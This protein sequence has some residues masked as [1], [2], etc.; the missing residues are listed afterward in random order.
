MSEFIYLYRG[1]N[2][3]TLSPE[4]MQKNMEK[5]VAWFKDLGATG[6][7]KRSRKS[8]GAYRQG[9][10]GKTEGDYRWAVC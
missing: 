1:I 4:E 6:H 2:I 7:L 3:S 8:S 10:Q 5:W 9:R